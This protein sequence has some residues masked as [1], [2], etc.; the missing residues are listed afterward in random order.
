M[1]DKPSKEFRELA[2]PSVDLQLKLTER[3]VH[4]PMR[5][6][7]RL[8]ELGKGD[9]FP[10]F[11]IDFQ[12][13]NEGVSVG[14]HQ[15]RKSPHG[16]VVVRTMLILAGD[17]VWREVRSGFEGGDSFD[18]GAKLLDGV[19]ISP[20]FAVVRA[21]EQFGLERGFAIDSCVSG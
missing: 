9:E 7:E 20:N 15:T 2:I 19:V 13:I 14:L 10:A 11:D 6:S 3:K 1:K 5:V 18:L 8:E 4:I 21:G 17:V 16:R 12:D